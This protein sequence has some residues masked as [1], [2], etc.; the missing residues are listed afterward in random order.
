MISSVCTNDIRYYIHA[1][2]IPCGSKWIEYGDEN[3]PCRQSINDY[4]TD[5]VYETE[6]LYPGA[7]ARSARVKLGDYVYISMNRDSTSEYQFQCT[8]NITVTLNTCNSGIALNQG[9]SS[10][11]CKPH[12]DLA[13][14]HA[15]TF[16]ESQ[17]LTE[18]YYR[19]TIPDSVAS[20]SIRLSNSSYSTYVR[21]NP[22]Y[23]GGDYYYDCSDSSSFSDGAYYVETICYNPPKGYFYIYLYTYSSG[24]YLQGDFSITLKT[25][26]SGE[27]GYNCSYIA[28]NATNG[29][30]STMYDI[31]PM[32]GA[33][34][35]FPDGFKGFY[36]DVPV[37]S[38]MR[39]NFSTTL[40][41][42]TETYLYYRR[43]GYIADDYDNYLFYQ[44]LSGTEKVIL[45][46]YD[47]VLGGRHMIW[48][49]N[50]G[51]AAVSFNVS[52]TAY[53]Y[54][55][56]STTGTTGSSTSSS[57]SGSTDGT[58]TI[59]T[60]GSTDGV[61]TSTSGTTGSTSG[62]SST[63]SSTSVATTG[64][65]STSSG[66]TTGANSTTSGGGVVIINNYYTYISSASSVVASFV[67]IALALFALI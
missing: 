23:P 65:T 53:I 40:L 45:T 52:N 64:S 49:S 8:Y 50:E 44:G 59:G 6:T 5:T 39:Y 36:I 46:W 28:Y 13:L 2:H 48:V 21:G 18:M 41:S 29:L 62:S 4:F 60:S 61:T 63:S 17:Q 7:S 19:L 15:S 38:S 66:S 27:G 35:G 1:D 3:Y 26:A 47:I 42:G 32:E 22:Y 56:T 57:T 37:N 55:S 34:A 9:S 25:C 20:I 33:S 43:N 12:T 58:T 24:Y 67:L 54:G 30:N 31:Q 51:S 14:P 10:A 16:N 11:E